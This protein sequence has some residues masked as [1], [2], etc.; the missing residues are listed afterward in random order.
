MK[1][2]KTTRRE[3]LKNASLLSLGGSGAFA[4]L[5][6]LNRVHAQT[7]DFSDYKALVCVF[8]LG[9]NDAFNT[10]VPRSLSEYSTYANTRLDLAVPR[11]D[12]LAINPATSD[13]ADYGL[14][15]NLQELQSLFANNRLALL[16]NVGALIEP[17]TQSAFVNRTAA[18]PPQLFS[19][20]DQQNFVMS[21]QASKPQQGWA[22][23]MA[24][25]LADA[26]NGAD[27]S[28]NVTLSGANTWQN[29]GSV[30]PYSL[31]ARGVPALFGLDANSTDEL[32][33]MRTQTFEALLAQESPHLFAREYA[34]V[35]SRARNVGA[36]LSTALDSAP[37][38]TTEFND[39]SRLATGL[40]MVARLIATRQSLGMRRQMFFVGIGDYD[41]HGDQATRHP[42]LMTE[43]SQS[44]DAFYRATV[45]LGMDQQVT[46]FTASDFG[47]TLT[48]N[49]DGTD[50]GWGGHQLVMGGAVNGGDIYGSMPDL[51]IGSAD[52]IGEG[53]IIPTTSVDQVAATLARWY[54][55][56][57]AQIAETF[58][59]LANFSVADLGFMAS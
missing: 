49:G 17:V 14:H 27:L 50:H 45:E 7:G 43:L 19:H 46:T 52:D 37:A 58:P 13:G 28:M 39:Q 21:L 56:G 8:L 2:T 47:R 33:Q 44:L 40:R 32:T 41:T 1:K 11:E 29:G 31:S 16:G 48:S 35:Q 53:R 34:I 10:L 51:A 5:S 30:V 42:L 4:T 15:P 20:N 3:F 18:L 6:G 12:L 57:P 54:G 26:N 38:L 24:D 9:G 36:Q 23:R 22:S 59:N 55:L 25:L